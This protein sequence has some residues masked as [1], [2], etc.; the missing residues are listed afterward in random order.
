MARKTEY[1]IR[2]LNCMIS[3]I[4][5]KRQWL[6]IEFSDTGSHSINYAYIIKFQ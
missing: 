1:V 3:E 2:G 6:V 5:G 4:L